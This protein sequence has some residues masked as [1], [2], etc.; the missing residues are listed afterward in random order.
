MLSVFI[1]PQVAAVA[2]VS[3][4]AAT[5]GRTSSDEILVEQ[6]AAIRNQQRRLSSRGIRP[7]STVGFFLVRNETLAEDLLSEVFLSNS[8]RARRRHCFG[9]PR[10]PRTGET[11]GRR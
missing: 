8:R 1:R 11:K 4:L 6:I 7:A 2:A 10:W 3:T 5:T 9:M